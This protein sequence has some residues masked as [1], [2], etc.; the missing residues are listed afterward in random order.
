MRRITAADIIEEALLLLGQRSASHLK[1]LVDHCFTK[2]NEMLS[3]WN[4]EGPLYFEPVGGLYE[5][6]NFPKGHVA[7]IVYN[8]AIAVEPWFRKVQDL[9]LHQAANGAWVD[10]MKAEESGIIETAP[11][12]GFQRTRTLTALELELLELL[13]EAREELVEQLEAFRMAA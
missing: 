1:Q 9:H 5:P 7:A 4:A 8:L 3:R 2:L 10:M 11:V 6:L 13:R 12:T